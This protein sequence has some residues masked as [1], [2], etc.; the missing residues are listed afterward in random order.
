M[1]SQLVRSSLAA[2]LARRQGRFERSLER[3]AL[4]Q[5]R[6]LRLVVAAAAKTE[7][8]R[9]HSLRG[10]EDYGTFARRVPIA[11]YDALAPWIEHQ[12]RTSD[13]VIAAEPIVVYEETSGSSGPCKHIPYTR[14]LL[15]IFN[16]TFLL[17]AG[18]LITHG[19]KFRT[20][21]MFLSISPSF[22]RPRVTPSGIRIGLKD[23]TQ[24][25]SP[26][27]RWVVRSRL[28]VPPGLDC[29]LTPAEYRM[30][31]GCRLIATPD[32]EIVSIWSPTYLLSLLDFL[33]RN[34]AEV[35]AAL[36]RGRV[37]AGQHMFSLRSTSRDRLDLLAAHPV[38]WDRIWPQL[39][40]L[41]AWTDASSAPFARHLQQRL[42]HTTL[43]GKG[44]L[45]TEAPVTLPWLGTAAPVPLVDSVLIECERADGVVCQV[46][47][48]QPGAEATLVVSP[49]GGLL[50]YR[51]YD[52]VRAGPR[53]GATPTLR[54]LGRDDQVSDLVGEK[55]HETFVRAT[56]G[57]VFGNSV[58]ALLTPDTSADSAP[59]YVCLTEYP[60]E[61]Q[62]NLIDGRLCHAF[63]YRQ[64]RLHGQLA[65][66]RIVIVPD[67]RLRYEKVFLN[68][69]IK[70]GDIKYTALLR[71]L[72]PGEFALLS[73]SSPPATA[74]P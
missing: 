17:W 68:R 23:D 19:P 54:F 46:H 57:E 73:G 29:G 44:L 18:N 31:L 26:F 28:V 60:M 8:G 50:R 42:P 25:L 55:L 41:S 21:R 45:S 7:Y 71:Q 13:R 30:V 51:T 11:D 47:E 74:I 14:T 66:P 61:V 3:P 12:M 40:L 49:P 22:R 72:S 56:L 38:R 64:A 27:V 70:L 5:D 32:L 62:A 35:A 53:V 1:L 65:E 69:K 59:R 33:E 4:A 58:F 34:A 2:A 15:D 48:L 16:H 63:H 36:A 6:V 9:A 37:Q 20:G 43:Q 52:R 67:L 39:K 24:Y 10:S